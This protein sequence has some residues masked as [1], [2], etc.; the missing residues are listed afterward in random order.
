MLKQKPYK[1][2]SPPGIPYNLL[3]DINIIQEASKNKEFEFFLK[4]RQTKG[5]KLI[6]Y[7][8]RKEVSGI[9]QNPP[10]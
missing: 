1:P 8:K 10:N 3:I 2:I 4:K 7:Q 5:L 6:I 9:K